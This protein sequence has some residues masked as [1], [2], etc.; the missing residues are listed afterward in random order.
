MQDGMPIH[1][2]C[3]DTRCASQRPDPVHCTSAN[4]TNPSR[5]H[6]LI[7]IPT[8]HRKATGSAYLGRVVRKL[9]LATSAAEANAPRHRYPVL[10]PLVFMFKHDSRQDRHFDEH[11]TVGHTLT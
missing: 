11:A 10:E 6:V 5:V 1:A 3:D 2:S 7:G 4:A 8:V 9:R